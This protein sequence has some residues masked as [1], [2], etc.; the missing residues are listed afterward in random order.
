MMRRRTFLAAAAGLPF[1]GHGGRAQ[2]S[3]SEAPVAP[4]VPT[5][6]VPDAV[7]PALPKLPPDFLWGASTSCYQIEG[8][9]K[10]DGRTDSIWDVFCRQ[11]GKI[12]DGTNGDVAC[13]HYN[14]YRDDIDLLAQGNFRAYRFSTAWPRILPQGTGA[15]NTAGLDFYD[16]LVDRLL[17]KG[18]EPFACLYHWDLPQALQQRGG[19]HNRDIAGWFADYAEVTVGRLGDRVKRWAMLNEPS[20]HAIFGHAFGNH[21]P[22]LTGWPSYVKAQ[23]HQNLAQGTAIAALRA[24]RNDLQLGT[25]FSLQP[26]APATDKPEDAAAARRVD[27]A[28]NTINLDPLFKGYYPEVYAADFET[29]TQGD[30]L[31]RIKVPVDFLGVNYYGPGYLVNAPGSV[32]A[33]A[34]WG[35]L[36]PGMPVTALGWPVDPS[37]LVRVLARLRDSYGNP[38]VFVTENGACYDDPPVTEGR[39]SDPQRVAYLRDH[40]FACRQAIDQGCA[41]RGYLVWSLLDNFEWA[42]GFRRRFGVVH[43]DFTTLVRTPKDSYRFLAEVMKPA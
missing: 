3:P 7:P 16:R 20:V 38:S 35:A 14:R 24:R 26:V 32:L 31:E 4:G 2:T 37:G 21:A 27:A 13:D 29:V 23:H 15:V 19:W 11:P 10:A 5:G 25:V 36:P 28:W 8:A 41:L 30:D 43:V 40:L 9:V 6:A 18:I 33:D 1:M 17:E 12:A 34:T 42:E 22:G 39:V